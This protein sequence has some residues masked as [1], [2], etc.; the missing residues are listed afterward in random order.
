MSASRKKLTV[1]LPGIDAGS[2]KIREKKS[3]PCG[4]YFH[5]CC[6][7]T[8]TIHRIQSRAKCPSKS[9]SSTNF[10]RSQHQPLWNASSTRFSGQQTLWHKFS[11]HF[12]ALPTATIASLRCS[13]H[14]SNR[15]LF[16]LQNVLCDLDQKNPLHCS[17]AA[18]I[19]QRV[20][21]LELQVASLLPLPCSFLAEIVQVFPNFFFNASTD[22]LAKDVPIKF[23]HRPCGT[24]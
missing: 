6:A 20:S 17:L 8:H 10:G 1:S 5:G 24:A 23:P 3:S 19:I 22:R 11:T 9:A 13:S 15:V 14:S 4:P 2:F 21:L 7:W 12:R 16:L 18:F